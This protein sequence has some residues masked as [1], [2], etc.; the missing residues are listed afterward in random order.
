MR[1]LELPTT[2]EDMSFQMSITGITQLRTGKFKT[3]YGGLKE[4]VQ[5]P[6]YGLLK[7]TD[8]H[9]E[10]NRLANVKK[11]PKKKAEAIDGQ[12]IREKK[13]RNYTINK[14][15]IT[16][17]IRNFVNQMQGEKKL[18]FW[19]ITFPLLTTD[20]S[21]FILFN[22]WLTRLRRDL[23][24]RSYLW[25]TERQKNGT[26]HF[27]I[28]LHQR[29]CVQ[30]A[31][32]FMRACLFT[33]IENN[34]LQFSHDDAKKY[35]GI[36]ISKNRKT[37]RVTNFALQKSEKSLVNYITK[38]VTKN[39]GKFKHLAWHSSRDYSNLVTSVRITLRELERW[40][41]MQYV[42]A[43]SIFTSEWFNFFKW[44]TK[45]PAPL[46]QHLA[47]VNQKVLSLLT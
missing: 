16:H 29:L 9:H 46:L 21:A 18:F 2:F 17:R 47:M 34:E 13:E 36:D 32:K 27:H 7:K 33:S 19:T 23:N 20:D 28:A 31:N 38:Y 37:R 3:R 8:D 24:L 12:A 14:R 45:P 44:L 30:K 43:E 42:H 10:I 1:I 11:Y 6:T 25:V 35:N 22:K 4:V 5:K 41:V 40:A 39:E 15:Q 26:I